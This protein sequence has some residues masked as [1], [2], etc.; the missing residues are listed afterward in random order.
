VGASFA[1]SLGG[2]EVML[3]TIVFIT[4]RMPKKCSNN[5]FVIWGMSYE[6]KTHP[7]CDSSPQYVATK[8]AN[9]CS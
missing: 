5:L 3:P 6:E 8:F 2:K 9:F 1:R 7:F 4:T